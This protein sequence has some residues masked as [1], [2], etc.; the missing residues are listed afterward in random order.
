MVL[1]GGAEVRRAA[2]V[3]VTLVAAADLGGVPGLRT[4]N[5]KAQ[6]PIRCRAARKRGRRA[7]KRDGA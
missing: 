1:R 4:R 7:S 5:L 6:G 2:G 3:T